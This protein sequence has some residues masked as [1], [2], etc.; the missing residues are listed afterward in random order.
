MINKI[1][2]GG[3]CFWGLQ[4]LIRRQ[5]GV[6]RTRAGYAGGEVK[7]PTYENHSGHAESVE[8]EYDNAKTTFKDLL[9][10][11]FRIHDPTTLNRQ[12]NDIGT[13]YR[14]VIFYAN[15][16]ERKEAENFIDIVNQSGRWENPVA[17]RLEPLDKFYLAEDYHQD[18]L[19]KHPNGYTCHFVRFGSYL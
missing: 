13:S 14:S 17:T 4:D 8:I 5:P 6:V 11:F 12:G 15:D 2:L 18:Y 7:D 10:F 9:D 1:V 19:R 16:N 3:G